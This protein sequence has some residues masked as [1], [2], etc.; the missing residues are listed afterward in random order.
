MYNIKY[1]WKISKSH[2]L[3]IW[4]CSAFVFVS[5]RKNSLTKS[6]KKRHEQTFKS[7]SSRK[8]LKCIDN[9]TMY[10]CY[11]LFL[12]CI[13]KIYFHSCPFA[14]LYIFKL[15]FIQLEIFDFLHALLRCFSFIFLFRFCLYFSCY[16]SNLRLMQ[17]EL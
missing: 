8:W 7:H 17:G 12:I 6:N 2:H 4:A 10:S 14:F 13:R 5:L 1:M 11:V 16:P 3:T 15:F 9:Q